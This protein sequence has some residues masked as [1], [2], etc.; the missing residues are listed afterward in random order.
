[1]SQEILGSSSNGS[2]QQTSNSQSGFGLLPQSIQNAFTQ[3]AG[4]VNNTTAN[5]NTLT[6]MFTPQTLATGSQSSLTNLENNAYAPTASNI[7]SN[8]AM[9]EN[10]YNSSVI[11]TINRQAQ[12]AGSVLNSEVSNAGQFGSNRAALGAN[13]IDLSRLQQ[14][15][16]FEQGQFNTNLQNALTTI[17]QAG[18][19]SAAASVG[20]GQT[21]QQQYA[22]TQQAPIAGLS[23]YSSLLGILP[24]TGGSTSTSQGTSQ[25][26]SGSSLGMFGMF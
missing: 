24:Q 14:I 5:P 25:Q 15:G 7:A 20:A 9:Q 10:P 22:A 8:I 6:S 16:D 26:Q 13:D 11:D 1:M 18:L 4:D 2:S 21:A 3:Y 23:A 17:P 19:T 12:G